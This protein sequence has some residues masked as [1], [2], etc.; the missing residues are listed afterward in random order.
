[1]TV[2]SLPVQKIKRSRS[3]YHVVG[4]CSVSFTTST[5]TAKR[6][7]HSRAEEANEGHHG[8]LKFGRSIVDTKSRVQDL[9]FPSAGENVHEW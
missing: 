8:Q 6:V 9:V 4:K 3:I 1:M 2:I 5:H 7:E